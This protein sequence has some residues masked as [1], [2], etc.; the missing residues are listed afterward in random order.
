MEESEIYVFQ[1]H[2]F[3]VIFKRQVGVWR[4][5]QWFRVHTTLM[6]GEGVT[7]IPST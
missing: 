2:R 7:L 5:A 6:G 1:S 4:E 3:N